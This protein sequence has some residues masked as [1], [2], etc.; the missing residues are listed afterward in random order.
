MENQNQQSQK[1]NFKKFIEDSK[2]TLFN[3]NDYFSKMPLS[4]GLTEPIIK[5][6]LYGAIIGVFAFVWMQLGIK[7]LPD[8]ILSGGGTGVMVLADKIVTSLIGLFIGSAIVLVFSMVL[9][10]NKDFEACVR[11]VASL[12]I[13]SVVSS[14]FSFLSGVNYYLSLIVS[15]A[16]SLWGLYLLYNALVYALKANKK[17]SRKLVIILAVLLFLAIILTVLL[18]MYTLLN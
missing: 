1:F 4:G 15:I 8:E 2:A 18:V 7:N 17:G 12:M 5:A 9:S 10:G 16:I 14:A 11:V 6:L 3:S 13:I